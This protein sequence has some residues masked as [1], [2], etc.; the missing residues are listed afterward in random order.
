M[1]GRLSKDHAAC[2]PRRSMSREAAQYFEEQGYAYEYRMA[3]YISP[4]I[5]YQGRLACIFMGED[6]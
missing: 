1:A 2:Q 4:V 6:L 3:G 5:R